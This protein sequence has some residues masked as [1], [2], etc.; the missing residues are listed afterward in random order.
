M[1]AGMAAAS[2]A[3]MSLPVSAVVLVVLLM[4]PLGFQSTPIV[5]IAVVVAFVTEQVL[6]H[7]LSPRRDLQP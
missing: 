6:E 2:V 4:G 7:G 1:A 3:T 5:L